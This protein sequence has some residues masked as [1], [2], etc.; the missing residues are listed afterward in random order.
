M[1]G[2][3]S[4]GIRT[5][6]ANQ[7]D[8]LFIEVEEKILPSLQFDDE[9]YIRLVDVCKKLIQPKSHY[10]RIIV[11]K[12]LRQHC[13]ELQIPLMECSTNEKARLVLYGQSVR[14]EN[15]QLVG[16]SNLARLINRYRMENPT[17]GQ[18]KRK[19]DNSK[20][21]TEDSR[22]KPVKKFRKRL[23]LGLEV[24]DEDE[25]DESQR[26]ESSKTSSSSGTEDFGDSS[27]TISSTPTSESFE[28]PQRNHKKLS[29]KKPQLHIDLSDPGSSVGPVACA[30]PGSSAGSVGS[31]VDGFFDLQ[32]FNEISNQNVTKINQSNVQRRSLTV[33]DL[34]ATALGPPSSK[35]KKT[36][37]SFGE[38]RK[39]FVISLTDED[40]DL[41]ASEEV[42]GE[43]FNMK[44]CHVTLLAAPPVPIAVGNCWKEIGAIGHYYDHLFVY[45]STPCIFC[46]QCKEFF[47]F[48]EFLQHSHGRNRDEAPPTI[49]DAKLF[50][51][52]HNPSQIR[53]DLWSRFCEK[54]NDYG[55]HEI[56]QPLPLHLVAY[57]EEQ[58]SKPE[59]ARKKKT[60]SSLTKEPVPTCSLV[61]EIPLLKPP[62]PLPKIPGCN[63]LGR[64]D[65]FEFVRHRHYSNEFRPMG[66]FMIGLKGN[67]A[68]A[69]LDKWY[70]SCS[71]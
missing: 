31:S 22:R 36:A 17:I 71:K 5:R 55:Y 26:S 48:V 23:P 50:L 1:P 63:A 28:S 39:S 70:P 58:K 47:A 56:V 2:E 46:W 65:I 30:V 25:S 13:A 29:A 49:R 12:K 45:E 33:S 24:E 37:N 60:K 59:S 62:P 40:F 35:K 66:N 67:E 61:D 51:F 20:R 4:S 8:I 7:R 34:I 3:L 42:L 6:N 44:P 64:G 69:F 38:G 16:L 53:F 14:N 10:V 57:Y 54:L 21:K 43:N 11:L 52:V 27:T 18:R 68:D 9:P 15:L 32:K 41:G 19:V